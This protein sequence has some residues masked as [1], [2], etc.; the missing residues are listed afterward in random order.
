MFTGATSGFADR[1]VIDFVFRAALDE[2]FIDD[3]GF[4]ISRSEKVSVFPILRRNNLSRFVHP[5]AYFRQT[6]DCCLHLQHATFDRL[7]VCLSADVVV[8]L[9][10]H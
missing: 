5:I 3:L 10:R 6:F 1:F 4:T 7:A 2:S 8:L 9:I